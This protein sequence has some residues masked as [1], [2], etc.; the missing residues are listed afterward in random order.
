M[1][2]FFHFDNSEILEVKIELEIFDLQ[3]LDQKFM[4]PNQKYS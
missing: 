4:K 1:I 3:L 2:Y